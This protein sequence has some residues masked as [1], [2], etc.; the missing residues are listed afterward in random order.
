M[1]IVDV[2]ETRTEIMNAKTKKKLITIIN[3]NDEQKIIK[4]IDDLAVLEDGDLKVQM[5]SDI[6]KFI[7][8]YFHYHNK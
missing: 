5:A 1:E 6:I 3:M 4:Y 8:M 7:K 2:K